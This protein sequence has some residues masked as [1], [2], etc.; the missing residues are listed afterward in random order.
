MS[1][2]TKRFYFYV[3]LAAACYSIAALSG[4]GRLGFLTFIGIGA[5]MEL[6]AARHLYLLLTRRFRSS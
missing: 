1:A 2:T 6:F 4:S 5:V 3:L